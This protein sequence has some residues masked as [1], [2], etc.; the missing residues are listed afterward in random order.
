MDAQT[1]RTEKKALAVAKFAEGC[2]YRE[3]ARAVRVHFATLWRWA[4]ADPEFGAAIKKAGADADAE[5]EAT[6]FGN[7]TDPD[8]SHN[9]LRM[10]WL[11]SRMPSRYQRTLVTSTAED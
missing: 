11:K 6:T 5:V 2:T 4:Q 3:T 10:F 9:V 8:P 7:A 1:K